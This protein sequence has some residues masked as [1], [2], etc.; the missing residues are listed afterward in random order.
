VAQAQAFGNSQ[1]TL[2]IHLAKVGQHPAALSDEL[3]KSTPTGL[4]FFIG[5]Q[6]IGQLLDA[7]SQDRD[8]NFGGAGIAV[9]AV[10]LRDEP[11]LDFF[12]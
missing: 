12:L 7:P 2:V 1:V 9:M 10:V 5:A 6:V 8:L 3:E 11:G 4:V